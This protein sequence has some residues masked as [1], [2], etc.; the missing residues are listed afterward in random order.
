M[1]SSLLPAEQQNAQEVL[2]YI[3]IQQAIVDYI[4]SAYLKTGKQS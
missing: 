3:F 4:E 2:L 1:I